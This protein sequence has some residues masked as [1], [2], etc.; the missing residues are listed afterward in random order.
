M[1]KYLTIKNIISFMKSFLFFFQGI[2]KKRVFDVV[3]YYPAH[4]NRDLTNENNLFMPLYEICKKNN[5]KFIILEEPELSVSTQRSKM[6]IPFDFIFIIILVFRKF[7]SLKKFDSF[8]HR[9][10]FIANIL[11]KVF[12]RKFTFKNYIVTSQSMLSFFRGLEHNAKLFD[13]QHGVITSNHK[14]YFSYNKKVPDNI[15]RNNVFL[16]V[17]GKGFKSLLKHT[18][19]EPYYINKV[20]ILGIK[21]KS[22]VFNFERKNIILFSLQFAD[23]K[24]DNKYKLEFIHKFLKENE[25]LFIKNNI[26]VLLKHHP[27]FQNDIDVTSLNKYPF[28]EFVKGDLYSIIK[29]ISLHVTLNSTTTFDVA[30]HGIPTLLLKNDF[31][32]CD[33]FIEDYKYPLGIYSIKESKLFIEKNILNLTQCENISLQV[34]NWVK[35]YYNIFDDKAFLSSLIK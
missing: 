15:K 1:S 9:D 18:C 26:K 32:P 7:I 12:F 14:A 8:Q 13:Y 10:Y 11:K 24:P 17:Y 19:S 6:A 29:N 30:V 2:Y 4:F 3:F 16:F 5:L 25:S 23:V 31:L 35:D 22:N 20:Y 21:Q 33:F 34:Y 27:R 28:T